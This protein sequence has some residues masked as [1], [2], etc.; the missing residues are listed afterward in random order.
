MRY[1]FDAAGAVFSGDFHRLVPLSVKPILPAVNKLRVM[2]VLA[3]EV[4]ADHLDVI[5]APFK[6]G[7]TLPMIHLG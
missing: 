6:P 2:I 7:S 4:T 5:P 1:P 3:V